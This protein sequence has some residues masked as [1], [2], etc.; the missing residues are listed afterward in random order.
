MH[1]ALKLL[2]LFLF[3]VLSVAQTWPS[4]AIVDPATG[5]PPPDAGRL[6]VVADGAFLSNDNWTDQRTRAALGLGLSRGL[7]LMVSTSLRDLAGMDAYQQGIEDTRLGLLVWPVSIAENRFR[8]GLNGTVILPTG[9]RTQESFYDSQADTSGIL[10]PFTLD[11]TAGEI[12]LGAVWSPSRFG[13]LRTHL[14]YFGS[15]DQVHQAFRW[16]MGIRLT[17][18]GGRHAVEMSYAQS[19]TRIG[20]YPDTESLFAGLDLSLGWGFSLMPGVRADLESDPLYGASIGLKFEMGLP[21]VKSFTG[22]SGPRVREAVLVPP[23]QSDLTLSDRDELWN[24]IRE[25]LEPGFEVVLPLPTLDLPGLPFTERDRSRFWASM[26]AIAEA[27]PDVRYLLI[28]SVEKEDV[29]R[30]PGLSIPLVIHQP[31]WEAQCR[32]RMQLIDL[33]DLLAWNQ[34]VVEGKA[35]LHE[36]VRFPVLSEPESEVLS[37]ERSRELKQK[38]YEMAGKE[39]YNQLPRDLEAYAKK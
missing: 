8:C 3:P 26:A 23:P 1:K 18:T 17:P 7:G 35:V 25:D 28:T 30:K 37:M 22:P 33:Y 19:L 11:Q 15:S 36:S 21:S 29:A 10:P 14:G 6:T 9:Y 32:M 31:T 13:A 24:R 12:S 20:E 38:A 39:I 4:G 27:H 34:T 2:I 16:G 5:V